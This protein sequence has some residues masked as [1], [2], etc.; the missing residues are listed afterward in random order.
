M[1]I[2]A[3][4]CTLKFGCKLKNEK[5]REGSAVWRL[6]SP[7]TLQL[8]PSGRLVRKHYIPADRRSP[9]PL[10]CYHIGIGSVRQSLA[11]DTASATATAAFI[12]CPR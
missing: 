6:C 9:P 11:A 1:A 7:N 5:K 12:Y 2:V 3:A 4:D 10:C 8:F